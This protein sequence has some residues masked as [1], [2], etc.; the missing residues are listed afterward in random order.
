[1]A[2]NPPEL[3]TAQSTDTRQRLD[4]WLWFS[5]VVKTRTLAQKLVRGGNV[6][7]NGTRIT[8]VSFTVGPGMV[9]TITHAARIFILRIV[10]PGTRR[11]PAPEAQLLYKDLSPEIPT[12]KNP[13]SLKELGGREPGSGRPTKKQ[14]RQTDHLL[15]RGGPAG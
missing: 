11:G 15:D 14:R 13:A 3:D 12:R 6:R 5:R 10:T 7:V 8:L 1:M 9:L 2:K 4:K